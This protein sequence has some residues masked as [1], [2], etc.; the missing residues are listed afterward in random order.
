MLCCPWFGPK[1]LL[2][3][4]VD[5]LFCQN[6]TGS[7]DVT[8]RSTNND[9]IPKKQ[10]NHLLNNDL[11]LKQSQLPTNNYDLN[12]QDG[13]TLCTLGVGTTFGASVMPG[14]SHSVSVVTSD[15]C[16]LLRVRRADFQE[17]FQDQSH[18]IGN[19]EA[20][21]FC[22]FTS[23]NHNR[24]VLGGHS[25]ATAAN[26][27]ARRAGFWPGRTK[28]S[29]LTNNNNPL[30]SGANRD[31]LQQPAAGNQN[32]TQRQQPNEDSDSIDLD[33]M[34]SAELSSQLM[35][36]GWVLR[37]LMLEQCPRLL[38]NRRVYPNQNHNHTHQSEAATHTGQSR[39]S[40]GGKSASNPG[41]SSSSISIKQG[42]RQLISR[43]SSSQLLMS[44]GKSASRKVANYVASSLMRV[45][46][47]PQAQPQSLA[48]NNNNN[49]KNALNLQQDSH[50]SDLDREQNSGSL[51]ASIRGA[52]HQ[53]NLGG[54][55]NPIGS[56]NSTSSSSSSVLLQKCMLGR[57]MVDWLLELGQTNTIA[58][59]FI[60]SRLQAISMWQVLLEQGIV[61]ALNPCPSSSQSHNRRRSIPDLASSSAA[62]QAAAQQQQQFSRFSDDLHAYYKFW[63][64]R[65]PTTTPNEHQMNSPMGHQSQVSNTSHSTTLL[66]SRPNEHEVCVA[67][68]SLWWSLKVLSKLGADACFRL[69]LSKPANERSGEEVDM[70]FEELQQLKALSH[71]T[72]GIKRQLA[73]CVS[74]EFHSKQNTIIFNQGDAGYSWFI[75]LR[76]SVNV[77]IVGKGVVC[78]L[79]DG[80]DFGKLALVNDAPRAATIVT[81]EPNCYF[82]RVDKQ[83]F[84][85]I[86][87]D[88]EANTVR[89]NEHGK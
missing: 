15:Q 13:V 78:T 50:S 60:M 24:V 34:D 64:D 44:S 54:S 14:K 45:N 53:Q 36:I 65:E 8:P 61:F 56:S 75:I 20:S 25:L 17:I 73:A 26:P 38:Q 31:Q 19:V 77:V 63:F 79:H 74:G 52:R 3:A 84:N 88:V 47:T 62:I 29:D 59:R 83:H 23:L 35:R 27:G 37:V 72:N 51:R 66:L 1:G 58:G 49:S 40:S 39:P 67:L 10:T 80:D 42:A 5:L 16:T 55:S 81:N 86:L 89:L 6:R 70:V 68:E 76:G 30:S 85:T 18:L 21:P 46:K 48:D 7:Y 69:I 22:S 57:E 71:L 87:R 41:S 11:N 33:T 32:E 28:P 82:L 9:S 2:L 43:G 12:F 4:S